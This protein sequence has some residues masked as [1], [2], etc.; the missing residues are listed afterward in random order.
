LPNV[1]SP[2]DTGKV[3]DKGEAN[4]PPEKPADRK[5]TQGKNP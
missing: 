1:G 5:P 2:A 4:L 3:E